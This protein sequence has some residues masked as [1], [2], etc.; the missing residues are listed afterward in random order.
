MKGSAQLGDPGQS[1]GLELSP[2]ASP[3]FRCAPCCATGR[4]R[5]RRGARDW[6]DSDIFAGTLGPIDFETH[7]TPGMLDLP[8]LPDDALSLTFPMNGI[9]G[10]YWKA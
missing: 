2:A 8:V 3:R 1:P 10:N 9:E 6:I 5:W 7:F 4:C